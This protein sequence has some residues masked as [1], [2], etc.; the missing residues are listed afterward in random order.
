MLLWLRAKSFLN[1]V[2]AGLASASS[3]RIDRACSHALSASAGLPVRDPKLPDFSRFLGE[4]ELSR[5]PQ[6][7]LTGG[8]IQ[9]AR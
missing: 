5:E 8:S 4:D 7:I 3:C 2:T 6:C 1:C 9:P